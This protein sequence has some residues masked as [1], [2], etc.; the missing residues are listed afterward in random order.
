MKV[1]EYKNK[2]VYLDAVKFKTKEEKYLGTLLIF[3][4]IPLDAQ[5]MWSLN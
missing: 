5:E 4:P 3:T 2:R 1:S